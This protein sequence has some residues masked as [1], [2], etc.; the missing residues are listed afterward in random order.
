MSP[1]ILTGIVSSILRRKQI[2]K[3][4]DILIM[5][6]KTNNVCIFHPP[7]SVLFVNPKALNLETD[8]KQDEIYTA[9]QERGIYM[10]QLI[11]KRHQQPG[12]NHLNC[13]ENIVPGQS[14][15]SL[16]FLFEYQFP[17]DIKIK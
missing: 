13:A 14:M 1:K 2:P 7:L 12:T 3:A 4:H 15:S 9:F 5:N 17:V 16:V 11:K 10:Q 8:K 6:K